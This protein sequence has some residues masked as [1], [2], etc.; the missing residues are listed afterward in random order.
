MEFF[1]GLLWE[2]MSAAGRAAYAAICSYEKAGMSAR[3]DACSTVI[4]QMLP[5]SSTS[6]SVF[7]SR[8]RVSATAALRNSM[9]SVSVPAK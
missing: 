8:F 4:A 9:Q 2:T 1:D 5:C 7:S 6:S 3:S